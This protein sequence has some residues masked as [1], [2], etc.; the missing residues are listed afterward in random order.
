MVASAPM[1]A[2]TTAAWMPGASKT[3]AWIST[4]A[5]VMAVWMQEEKMLTEETR[6]RRFSQAAVAE[7]RRRGRCRSPRC[8]SSHSASDSSEVHE[9]DVGH[10]E[11][12]VSG[13]CPLTPAPQP[14][15]GCGRLSRLGHAACLFSFVALRIRSCTDESPSL[16]I[17]PPIARRP[18]SANCLQ[19]CWLVGPEFGRR[20]RRFRFGVR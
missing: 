3:V 17:A 19:W 20:A 7:P 12:D 9:A 8:C 11:C 14:G 18:S 5:G 16:G 10:G 6:R 15:V 2:D 4:V 1:A 13:R